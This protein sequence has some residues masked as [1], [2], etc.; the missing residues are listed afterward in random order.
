MKNN[1]KCIVRLYRAVV[2][3]V[4]VAENIFWIAEKLIA[5]FFQMF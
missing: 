3:K 5:I 2:L 4:G 1:K